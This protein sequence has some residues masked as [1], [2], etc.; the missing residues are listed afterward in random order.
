MVPITLVRQ[1][2]AQLNQSN[3][4]RVS[5]FVGGTS[6]VGK[7]TVDGLVRS[8]VSMKVYIVGRPSSEASIRP[9]LD[10]LRKANPKADLRWIGA[11]VSLLSEVK[12]VCEEI[13][14]RESAV[15]LLFLSAG[16]AP[17]GGRQSKFLLECFSPPACCRA[18]VW[19]EPSADPMSR[20]L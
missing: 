8:G 2:N 4:P 19:G 3:A 6:G 12:R 9:F 18:R 14:R 16:Y 7:L 17:F 1:S 11:E 15:D 10:E 13:S 20:Y 5:V